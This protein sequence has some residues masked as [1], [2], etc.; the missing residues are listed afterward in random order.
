MLNKSVV[1]STIAGEARQTTVGI[2]AADFVFVMGIRRATQYVRLENE[3]TR[4]IAIDWA[5]RMVRES[6]QRNNE[7]K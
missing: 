6:R 2:A 3:W 5:G 7:D 1:L 4:R